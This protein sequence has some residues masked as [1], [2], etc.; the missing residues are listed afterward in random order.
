MPSGR[1]LFTNTKCI[2]LAYYK[3]EFIFTCNKKCPRN[4]PG[5]F[6]YLNYL[7]LN[8]KTFATATTTACIGVVEIK[9][10]PI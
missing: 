1:F 4:K 10:F 5:T 7:L 3:Q 6:A 8:R 9:A 2:P